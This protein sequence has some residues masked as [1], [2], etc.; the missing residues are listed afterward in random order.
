MNVILQHLSYLLFSIILFLP[1]LLIQRCMS[2][3]RH[4]G[5][6][7]KAGFIYNCALALV[8]VNFFREGTFPLLA[9]FE[10]SWIIF[11][12]LA[13]TCLHIRNIGVLEDKA[14]N[15]MPSSSAFSKSC[16][17][18]LDM[19]LDRGLSLA[20]W[21][22]IILATSAFYTVM[23]VALLIQVFPVESLGM[24]TRKVLGLALY[25][26]LVALGVYAK[27]RHHQAK[28]YT[29]SFA[30]ERTPPFHLV[31]KR[32]QNLFHGIKPNFLLLALAIFCAAMTLVLLDRLTDFDILQ[33]PWRT[34]TKTIAY[35]FFLAV[36]VVGTIV[37]HGMKRK[38]EIKK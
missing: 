32:F 34:I 27:Y 28:R 23:I 8:Q 12:G 37:H 18:L 9:S 1:S 11:L 13:F 16:I 4:R 14:F 17:K 7:F 24:T 20:K 33:S 22:L 5:L 36:W 15:N 6:L 3:V 21:T 30:K 25:T 19:N 29:S 10:H 26:S 35:L 2:R 38:S 31:R